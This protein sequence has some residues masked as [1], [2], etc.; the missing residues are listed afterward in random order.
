MSMAKKKQKRRR[1]VNR[2][3]A[4]EIWWKE[5]GQFIRDRILHGSTDSPAMRERKLMQAGYIWGWMNRR[6][7]DAKLR[8]AHPTEEKHA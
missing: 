3:T 1:G 2:D 8:R 4:F 7:R 5:R 6:D